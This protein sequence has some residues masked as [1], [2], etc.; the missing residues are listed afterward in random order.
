MLRRKGRLCIPKM[1]I[2]VQK[3]FWGELAGSIAAF[4]A[5]ASNEKNRDGVHPQFVASAAKRV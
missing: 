2:I 3:M 4:V 5:S 1:P